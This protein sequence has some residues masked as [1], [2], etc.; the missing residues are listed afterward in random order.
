MTPL[1]DLSQLLPRCRHCPF[2]PSNSGAQLIFGKGFSR[3]LKI[4]GSVSPQNALNSASGPG[5]RVCTS[6][7][8]GNGDQISERNIISNTERSIMTSVPDT[9][10]F[11]NLGE[12]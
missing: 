8:G 7:V 4:P 6:P 9:N 10:F 2:T 1:N 5:S 11:N 12:G 3:T